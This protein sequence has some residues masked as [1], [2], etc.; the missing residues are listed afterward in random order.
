MFK[1]GLDLGYGF[2]KGINEEGKKVLMPSLVGTGSERTLSRVFGNGSEYDSQEVEIEASA[3]ARDENGSLK[4]FTASGRY[5]VGEL[6]RKESRIPAFAFDRN[7]IA[8]EATMVLIG[9]GDALLTDRNR[10]IHIVTG[11]PLKYFKEQK[12][13]FEQILKSYNADIAFGD[14]TKRRVS[15]AKTTVFPQGAAAVYALLTFNPDLWK[16][17]S[18]IILVEV[19]FKT[20]EILTFEITENKT[21][22]PVSSAS[23]TLELGTSNT[24]KDIIDAVYQK[25]G[26]KIDSAMAEECVRREGIVY[27]GKEVGL[28]EVI[29]KSRRDIARTIRDEIKL[30][31]GNRFDFVNC[32]SLAGGGAAD[33]FEFFSDFYDDV[34]MVDD[35][36]FANA[37]GYLEVA[38]MLDED[39]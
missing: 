16:P 18:A 28:G 20:T 17:G 5:F 37:Y 7:K 13:A 9:V 1:I 35:P 36:Q 34:R 12:K 10:D 31:I 2:L 4:E 27:R 23:D 8:H 39:L 19:G 30:I 33:L 24:V 14:G 29:R 25:L 26:V 32:V 11:P 22:V 15:F 3:V 38:K 21:I 6:A